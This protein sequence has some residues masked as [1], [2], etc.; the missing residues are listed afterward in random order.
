MSPFGADVNG[1]VS[2]FQADV[3]GEEVSQFRADV[4]SVPG[5]S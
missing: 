2:Q 3:N 5:S 4:N 1:E